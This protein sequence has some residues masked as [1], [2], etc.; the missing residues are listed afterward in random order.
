MKAFL[1][2]ALLATVAGVSFAHHLDLC[3]KND[4]ELK[5]ELDCIK[6]L[7]SKEAKKS[8]DKAQEAL[9]CQDWSCVI[10]K[11][12]AGGDLEGAM[13]QYFTDEQITEIH[14]AATACDPDAENEEDR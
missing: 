13:E 9:G 14:N 3:K 2:C 7:I 10:R 12:C 8:F 11:L 4:K 5:S 6:E 1:V